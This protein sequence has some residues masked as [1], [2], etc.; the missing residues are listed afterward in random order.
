ML[1]GPLRFHKPENVGGAGVDA[2]AAPVAEIVLN[3]HGVYSF[4]VGNDLTS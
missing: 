1:P 3:G 4:L 2:D